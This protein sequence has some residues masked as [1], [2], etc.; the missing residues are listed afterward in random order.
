MTMKKLLLI[1]ALFSMGNI[2]AQ[3][4]ERLRPIPV[5]EISLVTRDTSRYRSSI[6]KQRC[7][8]IDT[9]I[10]F[11]ECRNDRGVVGFFVGIP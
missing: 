9:S 8:Y 6:A 3:E 1:I 11:Y 10:T 4:L 2:F 5:T 7:F